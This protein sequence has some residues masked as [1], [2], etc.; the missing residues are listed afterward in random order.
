M[1]RKTLKNLTVSE[2]FIMKNEAITRRKIGK[3]QVLNDD[4]TKGLMDSLNRYFE[5][6]T[7]IPRMKAGN[8]QTF[9]TLINEEALLLAK[10]LRNKRKDS[11]RLSLCQSI[12]QPH[13]F[14]QEAHL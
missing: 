2:D 4:D 14:P 13:V 9:E 6:Q 7:K 3:R 5:K 11:V 8:R 1:A 12:T 10:Y